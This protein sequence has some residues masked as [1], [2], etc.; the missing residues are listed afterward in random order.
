MGN[1]SDVNF[2]EASELGSGY[3]AF[4]SGDYYLYMEASEIRQY[5]DEQ[6]FECVFVIAS[7]DEEGAKVREWFQLWT[8]RLDK[9][10]N[11]IRNMEKAK[12]IALC[13][14]ILG[15]PYPI[16]GESTSLHNKI[17]LAHIENIA[18]WNKELGKPDPEKRTNRISFTKDSIRPNK[19]F[20]N[21]TAQP[22]MQTASQPA[23]ATQPVVQHAAPSPTPVKPG[24]GKAPWKK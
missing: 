5:G 3:K 21:N 8:E 13:E 23:P 7:G 17:F 1:L 20:V 14:A 16:N 4:A 19:P 11:L 24:T 10:G 2:S 15:Q 6:K 12:V 9:N 18:Q 22:V